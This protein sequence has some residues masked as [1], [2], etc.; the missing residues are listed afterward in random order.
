ME[1]GRSWPG[2]MELMGSM[3]SAGRQLTLD[4]LGK[5]QFSI[6]GPDMSIIEPSV[7]SCV[8]FN[9]GVISPKPWA[10]LDGLGKIW[11]WVRHALPPSRQ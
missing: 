11:L 1:C 9:N 10:A 4:V 3:G 5:T 7:S 2:A 6:A 8:L